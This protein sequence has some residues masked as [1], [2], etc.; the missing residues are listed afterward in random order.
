MK[1][2]LVTGGSRGIGFGVVKALAAEG[3]NILINGMRPEE[4][5]AAVLEEIRAFGVEAGYAQGDI[6]SAEGRGKIMAKAK[7]T[8]ISDTPRTP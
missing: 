5:V 8:S 2:A 6:G 4:S 1:T 3:W 7:R